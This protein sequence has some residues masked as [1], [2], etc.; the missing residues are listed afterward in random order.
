MS[1]LRS[2]VLEAKQRLAE[3]LESSGIAM[4]KDVPVV[5]LLAALSDL[6]MV[7]LAVDR[8]RSWPIWNEDGPN[9]LW[10]EIAWSPMPAIPPDVA[11]L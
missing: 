4:R 1:F 8:G 3:G 2:N 7:P 9:G 11:P 5:D 10:S 6:A